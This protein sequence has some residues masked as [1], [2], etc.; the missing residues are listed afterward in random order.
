MENKVHKLIIL[1][2]GPAGLT[3]AIY[4]A[5][6]NLEPMIIDGDEPGGQLVKTTYVENWP[7][8]KSIL[9]PK[10]MTN[11]REHAKHFGTEFV[12][13]SVTKVDF[14][15]KPFTI[16]VDDKTTLQGHA[17]IIATGATPKRL[18][19][20]GEDKHWGK[21][22][23]TC[24]IC[25][26]AFYRDKKVVIV[27]GGDTAMEDASFLKKYTNKITIV[28]IL[29]KFT[30]SHA[31]QQRVINDPDIKVLYDS[32]VT[33]IHGDGQHVNGVTITNQKD[34]K[35]SKLEVDGVFIAI[36]LNPN[37]APFKDCITCNKGGFIEIRDQ[38]H[39]NIEGVFVAGDVHDYRYR[40]AVTAA[41]AGCM[42]ALD[43][44]RY[45]SAAE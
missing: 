43:V 36:G 28:H 11:M 35:T 21:G 14:S 20:P 39:T 31:M 29:D 2:S 5:R 45:L 19:V 10:L 13:G 1:G 42:A 34:G 17:I 22:V 44:E 38:T 7:G 33:E 24:A 41:G 26:G 25:D 12:T 40:Q 30:A 27:G 6:A 32:T 16:T 23:T 15:K 4:A 8:E 3:A 18:G 37:S 9:G